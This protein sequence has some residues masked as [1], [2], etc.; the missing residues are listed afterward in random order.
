MSEDSL[1][2]AETE[3]LY[4]AVHHFSAFCDFQF[5]VTLFLLLFPV[6]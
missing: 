3:E 6:R 5:P 2:L 1:C 4:L